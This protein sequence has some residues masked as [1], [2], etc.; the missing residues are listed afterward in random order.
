M[1]HTIAAQDD[2]SLK[3]D[4]DVK[5]LTLINLSEDNSLNEYILS[6]RIEGIVDFHPFSIDEIGGWNVFKSS[7][8][9]N[10]DIDFEYIGK[11]K[12]NLFGGTYLRYKQTYK[13]VPILDAGFSIYFDNDDI[14]YAPDGPVGP[15][16][17]GPCDQVY[18]ISPRIY[19][20]IN[21]D[22]TPIILK[23]N[24]SMYLNCEAS[25]IDKS[26]L[27]IVNNLKNSCEYSLVWNVIYKHNSEGLRTAFINANN[28]KILLSKSVNNYKTAP[29]ADNGP[30]NMID[31]EDGNNTILRNDRLTA[32]DMSGIN[33]IDGNPVNSTNQLGNEFDN[34]DIPESP[35]TRDWIAADATEEV[36]QAFWM[37][38]QAL[39]TFLNDFGIEFEDVRIGIHPNAFGATSFGPAIPEDESS[40]VFGQLG[41]NS[42]VTF[43]V[44]GHEL[45]HT[46]LREFISS[47]QIEGGSL[48]EAI[49][50]MFGT[51][52]ESILDP[53]GL[54]WVMGDDIPFTVRDLQNTTRN[55]FTTIAGST[56]EHARG[57][58]LGHWFFLCVNGDPLSGIQPVNMK[59]IL[60]I[61][62]ETLP[63]LGDNPDY[64]ALMQVVRSIAGTKYG[65]CSHEYESMMRAWDQICIPT[66]TNY[67][68]PC[69]SLIHI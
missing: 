31:E 8:T 24:L 40:F 33:T 29:T 5:N 39:E 27:N 21:L 13:G 67:D 16:G 14:Q 25:D 17:G 49:S 43:D 55:C 11:K 62:I 65:A 34:D 44:I 37:T 45:M 48:H 19:E 50:D 63:S 23:Q 26:Q 53:G 58:A 46:A 38:E 22:V 10:A 60:D 3:N 56:S 32:F 41:G 15:T 61:I 42:A 59:D 30:Q 35:R 64:E 12:S 57:E 2:N 7:L 1:S 54:D 68:G 66:G 18:S 6:D 69:L 51:Y 52:I 28:G 9:N 4:C 47:A 36:F 20:N